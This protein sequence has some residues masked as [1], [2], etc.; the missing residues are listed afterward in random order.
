MDYNRKCSV[1][2]GGIVG[3]ESQGACRQDE[4]IGGKPQ[5]DSDS[6]HTL[7]RKV[8]DLFFLLLLLFVSRWSSVLRKRCFMKSSSSGVTA[9]YI[10]ESM[11]FQLWV[12]IV[13]SVWRATGWT[14]RVRFLTVQDF[15]LLHRFQIRSTQL[16]IQWVPGAISPGVKWPG[17]EAD[18]L[19]LEPTSR[20]MERYLHPAY[21][22]MA[23]A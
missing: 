17:L 15:S 6:G 5:S 3:R 21:V 18:H 9:N 19:Y 7:P 8:G 16:P 1:G 14:V 13:Q 10:F 12:G 4:L 2:V 22:V 20:V 23:S 11:W